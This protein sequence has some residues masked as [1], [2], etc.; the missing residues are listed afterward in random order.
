MTRFLDV[1]GI[2]A[3]Y[4]DAQALRDISFEVNEGEIVGL[5]GANGAGKTTLMRV[6]AGLHPDV[7]SIDGGAT[8]PHFRHRPSKKVIPSRRRRLFG[9]LNV[10]DNLVGAYARARKSR[11]R[12]QTRLRAFPILVNA[13]TC[14]HIERWSTT[15]LAPRRDGIGVLMP[16]DLL[17]LAPSSSRTF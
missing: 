16:D 17:G 6:I 14:A 5:I 10:L 7:C 15:M 12:L 9:G 8:L 2:D 11:F 1:H 13:R 3:F 4:G